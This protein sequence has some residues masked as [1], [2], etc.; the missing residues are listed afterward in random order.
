MKQRGV[1]W[2]GDEARALGWAEFQRLAKSR[3]PLGWEI[4]R[5]PDEG[6]EVAEEEP[7]NGNGLVQV[8]RDDG[9]WLRRSLVWL[10]LARPKI[11][12]RTVRREID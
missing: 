4:L 6:T 8:E 2:D 12:R 11:T 10:G 5:S 7:V 3:L 1:I 9:S